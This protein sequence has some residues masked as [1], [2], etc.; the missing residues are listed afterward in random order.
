MGK[1]ALVM[2]YFQQTYPSKISNAFSGILQVFYNL[3]GM[4]LQS[5]S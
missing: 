4:Y 3:P 5:N 2:L 1:V